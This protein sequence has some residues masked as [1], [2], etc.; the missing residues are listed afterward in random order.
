MTSLSKK[1][2]RKLRVLD[3]GVFIYIN[4]KLR[5]VFTVKST[6]DPIVRMAKLL[7]RFHYHMAKEIIDAI[8][9]ERGTQV[10]LAAVEKFGQDRVKE[11]YVEASERGLPLDSMETYRKVRDMPGTGWNRDPDDP[12]IITY[13]PMAS[14][15]AEY[16]GEGNRIGYLYCSIDHV[17]YCGFGVELERPRCLALGDERCEF[18]AKPKR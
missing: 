10:V 18:R 4:Y 14:A 15:W 5:E 16:G 8:G 13:C 1:H 2:I 9:P 6:E 12:A 7:A 17:L 3:N 11:M